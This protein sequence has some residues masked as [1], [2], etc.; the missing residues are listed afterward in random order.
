[1]RRRVLLCPVDRCE[2]GRDGLC[3]WQSACPYQDEVDAC[4]WRHI[5]RQA[6]VVAAR[7]RMEEKCRNAERMARMREERRQAE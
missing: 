2:W 7:R 1:M 5:R 6:L 4:C 3:L